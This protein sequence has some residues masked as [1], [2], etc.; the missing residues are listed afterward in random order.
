[1]WKNVYD[2]H[3]STRKHLLNLILLVIYLPSGPA[4]GQLVSRSSAS[5]W[6]W[7]HSRTGQSIGQTPSW[8]AQCASPASCYCRRHRFW[9]SCWTRV[10]FLHLTAR[11]LGL[12]HTTATSGGCPLMSPGGKRR[13]PL[14]QRRG[15]TCCCGGTGV[16]PGT[17]C[18]FVRHVRFGDQNAELRGQ[19]VEKQVV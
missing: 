11:L 5:A 6:P 1:M 9:I 12:G 10:V 4:L 8:R 16:R 19:F 2:A 3:V 13:Q 15:P 14:Q 17:Q 7:R 18:L